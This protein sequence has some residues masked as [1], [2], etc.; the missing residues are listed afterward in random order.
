MYFN[1][2]EQGVRHY[3]VIMS[4]T[5]TAKRNRQSTMELMK[6]L[7]TGD[8]PEEIT[9]LLLGDRPK[10]ILKGEEANVRE[11]TISPKIVS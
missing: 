8:S 1:T 7:L 4:L 9:K 10:D 6:K 3:E 5:Q 11:Y 2:T